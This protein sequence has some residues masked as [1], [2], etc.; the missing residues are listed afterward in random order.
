MTPTKKAQ[1]QRGKPTNLWL[2]QADLQKLRELASFVSA[3]ARCSDSQIMRAALTLAK[4][5]EEFWKAFL[6][7][8][9]EDGRRK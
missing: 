9:Q 4:A 1:G 6:E 3:R 8:R 7:V 2:H 5:N